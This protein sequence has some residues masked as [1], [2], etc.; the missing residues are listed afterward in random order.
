MRSLLRD[1]GVALYGNG[2]EAE[3]ARRRGVDTHL[4]IVAWR[5]IRCQKRW[6]PMRDPRRICAISATHLA[7]SA[8]ERPLP[9][10]PFARA[11]LRLALGQIAKVGEHKADPR[12]ANV[13][14][15]TPQHCSAT[16]GNPFG[17]TTQ[18]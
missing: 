8:A 5:F 14:R 10:K 17:S 1:I 6:S 16:P 15:H 18:K 11:K 7:A 2:W 3:I 12:R 13:G 4:L 9:T